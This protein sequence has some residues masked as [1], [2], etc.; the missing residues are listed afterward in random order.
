MASTQKSTGIQL[1][2]SWREALS[3]EFRKDYM[4]SLKE[5]L[6]SQ[7]DSG[8]TIFPRGKEYFAAMNATPLDQVKVVIIGQDPYHGPRQAHGLSFSVL[9][10]VKPPP[11]LLNIFKE[12]KSDLGC[13]PPD[14]GCLI[15]WAQQGVLLLNSVLTVEHGRAGSH[16][17]KG[18]E[19]FTDQVV[20]VLNQSERRLAF[21]LWGSYAQKKGKILDRKKHY[22]LEGVHPSPLSAHKGFF[23]T[24]P[25]SKVNAFL[26]K[27]GQPEIDWCLPPLSE[28]KLNPYFKKL[29][30]SP[31]LN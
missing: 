6:K 29:Q 31:R 25:F 4:L 14:H 17:G 8:R 20:Q 7:Y 12:L 3:E 1:E 5:F 11:S 23:G 27:T 15:T 9:P 18:W 22:V 19:K 26:K 30:E 28:L 16:Q 13:A 2:S 21:I 10:G 24:R